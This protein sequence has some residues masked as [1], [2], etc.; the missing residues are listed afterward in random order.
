MNSLFGFKVKCICN[1]GLEP[2]IFAAWNSLQ[3]KGNQD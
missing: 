1:D 2:G 3:S